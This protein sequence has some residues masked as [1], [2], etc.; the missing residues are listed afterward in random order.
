MIYQSLGIATVKLFNSNAN[1]VNYKKTWLIVKG[2]KKLID[3]LCT[4]RKFRNL[5][6]E[7]LFFLDL[8]HIQKYLKQ[9]THSLNLI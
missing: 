5:L 8:N 2:E 4:R 9:L 1:S 3:I 6:F 7:A